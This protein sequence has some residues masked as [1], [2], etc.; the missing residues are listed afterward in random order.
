M[1]VA[2]ESAE[3]VGAEARVIVRR[4]EAPHESDAVV[5]VALAAGV[6][7]KIRHFSLM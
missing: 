1:T 3:V 7:G 6:V 2:A 4:A 5:V